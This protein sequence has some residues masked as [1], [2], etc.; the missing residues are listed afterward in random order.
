ME[1]E[2][3]AGKHSS[4]SKFPLLSC[5]L[6]HL[7]DPSFRLPTR[8]F[9]EPKQKVCVQMALCGWLASDNTSLYPAQHQTLSIY[10]ILGRC[11]G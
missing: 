6:F 2:P 7:L 5:Y 10:P 11:L 9:L 8:L 1:F 4:P 3:I